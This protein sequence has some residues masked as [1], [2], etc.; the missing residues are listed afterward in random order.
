M[1]LVFAVRDY[2]LV[3]VMYSVG[4]LCGVL[5]YGF[6]CLYLFIFVAC[7]YLFL[8]SAIVLYFSLLCRL[9]CG[10]VFHGLPI[11]V[12][13]LYLLCIWVFDVVLLCVIIV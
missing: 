13:V 3:V 4:V 10:F 9:C 1:L 6:V 7:V 8:Y 12:G 5:V 2:V 11:V